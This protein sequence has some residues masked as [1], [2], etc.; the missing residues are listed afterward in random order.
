MQVT[1][2]AIVVSPKNFPM[3]ATATLEF[4]H[5]LIVKD[6][7]IVQ[8]H[9]KVIVAMPSRKSQVGCEHCGAKNSLDA[10]YCSMCGIEVPPSDMTGKRLHRE[11]AHPVNAAFRAYVVDVIL[12][13]YE[14]ERSRDL[15][16]CATSVHAAT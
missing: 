5:C 13:A 10:K 8:S 2:I 7:R 9:G 6:V 14:R 15:Q 12:K 1:N 4:D 11:F 3:L 16:G